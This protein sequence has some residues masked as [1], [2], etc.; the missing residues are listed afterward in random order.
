MFTGISSLLSGPQTQITQ[1]TLVVG[2]DMIRGVFAPVSGRL[3][4]ITKYDDGEKDEEHMTA[5]RDEIVLH[6]DFKALNAFQIGLPEGTEVRL[7]QDEPV[8]QFRE[9]ARRF[10]WSNGKF[11]PDI[12]KYL[13]RSLLGKPLP[14]F[15]RLGLEWNPANAPGEM[16]LV[17]FFD[18]NQ[19]SSRNCMQQV[20]RKTRLFTE[21][22]A[23]LC[24]IQAA[25]V[26]KD[27][28]RQ[29]LQK[30]GI[31]VPVGAVR[32]DEEETRCSWGVRALPWLILTDRKHIVR[33]EGFSLDELESRIELV[34]EE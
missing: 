20:A 8:G 31:T 26:E 25:R 28:L 1:I 21:Q 14:S 4:S 11:I 16:L 9:T 5:R 15:E 6:P 3:T 29:W 27:E 17:C 33:A 13:M 22:G 32:V 18:L 30:T 19:R 24:G 34:G 23:V 10:R 2:L 12:N 7:S